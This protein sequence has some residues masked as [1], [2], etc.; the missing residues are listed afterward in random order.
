MLEKWSAPIDIGILEQHLTPEATN[1]NT[2]LK[3]VRRQ[4]NKLRY[5]HTPYSVLTLFLLL[6][7]MPPHD[8]W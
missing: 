4:I 7:A 8:L 1:N 3:I 2:I 6:A 5:S